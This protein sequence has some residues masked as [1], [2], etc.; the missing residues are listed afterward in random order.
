M[1]IP[2]ER[3]VL[4]D[5][6]FNEHNTCYLKFDSNVK[7]YLEIWKTLKKKL[8]ETG[9]VMKI[10]HEK[11]KETLRVHSNVY[12][13]KVKVGCDTITCK[14]C[15]NCNNYFIITPSLHNL[16]NVCQQKTVSMTMYL[17]G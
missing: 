14:Y 3:I 8:K 4:V 15:L 11:L 13:A 9:L 7:E 5:T 16:R 10:L 2:K 17:V 6:E 1:F 12:K